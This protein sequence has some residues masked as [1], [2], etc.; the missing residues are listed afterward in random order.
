MDGLCDRQGPLSPG[1]LRSTDLRRLSARRGRAAP[2]A[3]AA[4]G[5]ERKR[6]ESGGDR[7]CGK[8]ANFYAGRSRSMALA[9]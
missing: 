8:A 5:W 3:P 2:L 1:A 9:V 7:V 6:K 4:T